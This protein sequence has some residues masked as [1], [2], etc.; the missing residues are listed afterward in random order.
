MVPLGPASSGGPT[1]DV[2]V[3]NAQGEVDFILDAS[4]WFGS[5]AGSPA[6]GAQ[7]QAIGPTRIC[8]TRAG[9]G[10][11]CAGKTLGSGATLVVAVAGVAGIPGSG[12]VAILANLTAVDG[13]TTTYLF[14]YPADQP[15]NYGSDINVGG[16]EVLANLIATGLSSNAPSGDI[17]LFNAAGSINAVIDVDGWFS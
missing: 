9:S 1:T 11:A 10:T 13:S 17:K 12:P 3:F 2:C 5:A 4:G 15:H 8:D 14:T 7:F 6:V 16:G